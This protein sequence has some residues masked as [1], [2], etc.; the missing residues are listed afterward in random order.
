MALPAGYH[1]TD[2][3]ARFGGVPTDYQLDGYLGSTSVNASSTQ[4]SSL[5]THRAQQHAGLIPIAQVTAW[6]T[7]H[8]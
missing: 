8:S 5:A 3:M 1:E 7:A 6:L 4:K 2:F